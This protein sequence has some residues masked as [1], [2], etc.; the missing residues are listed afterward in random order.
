MV[1]LDHFTHFPLSLKTR[2]TE[3]DWVLYW[4]D[5]LVMSGTLREC[6]DALEHVCIKCRKEALFDLNKGPDVLV[7]LLGLHLP[8]EEAMGQISQNILGG[9]LSIEGLREE[10]DIGLIQ[11]VYP[12]YNPT[13][14]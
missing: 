5:S 9:E 6:L 10:V 1:L 14:N 3:G 13:S 8:S 11:R 7:C 4:A 12:E 2:P